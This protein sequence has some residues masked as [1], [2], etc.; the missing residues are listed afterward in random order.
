MIMTYGNKL[1]VGFHLKI[2]MRQD[3]ESIYYIV[4]GLITFFNAFRFFLILYLDTK[5]Y[6]LVA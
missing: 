2:K 4:A 5:V 6:Y 3:E 1:K